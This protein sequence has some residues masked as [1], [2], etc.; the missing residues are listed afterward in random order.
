[1]EPQYADEDPFA[2][3]MAA[4]D[5]QTFAAECTLNV[6]RNATLTLGTDSLIVLGTLLILEGPADSAD[7]VKIKASGNDRALIAAAC[8]RRVSSPPPEPAF[9]C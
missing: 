1:M 8:Y 3:P 5:Q 2:D 4:E 7:F 6:S 9:R